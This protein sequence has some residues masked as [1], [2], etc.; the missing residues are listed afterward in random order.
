MFIL[1]CCVLCIRDIHSFSLLA[2]ASRNSEYLILLYWLLSTIHS[3]TYVCAASIRRKSKTIMIRKETP[4]PLLM[5]TRR[6][7]VT[8]HMRAGLFCLLEG[9][10]GAVRLYLYK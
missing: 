9:A 3:S 6:L 2:S 7:V 10:D 8:D 4:H 1:M 5:T